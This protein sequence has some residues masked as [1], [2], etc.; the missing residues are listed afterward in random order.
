MRFRKVSDGTDR[1]GL[2]GKLLSAIPPARKVLELGRVM[3]GLTRRYKLR[4]ASA[5]WHRADIGATPPDEDG[6][7]LDRIQTVNCDTPDLDGFDDDYDCIVIGDA[8]SQV[9]NPQRL[10]T[11]L[12]RITTKDARLIC[13]VANATHVSVLEQMLL[14]E[15]SSPGDGGTDHGR[16]W[17]FSQSSVF[18]L[19]LDSGWLPQLKDSNRAN[20]PNRALAASVTAGSREL[21]VSQEAAERILNTHRMIVVCTKGEEAPAVAAVPISVIVPVNNEVQFD[22]NVA[23]SPG[24]HEIGAQ[25]VPCRGA[26]SA[27]DALKQG[28]ARATGEWLV[29]CHQDVYFPAGSGACLSALL[30]QVPPEQAPGTILGFSGIGSSLP[31]DPYAHTFHSGLVIDRVDCYDLPA[32]EHAVSVDELAI[33]LHRDTRAVIDPALGWHLWATDLCLAALRHGPGMQARIVR[34]PLFHN[35]MTGHAFIPAFH[36]SGRKLAAKYPEIRGIRTLCGTI[37]ATS[38]GR[39]LQGSRAWHGAKSVIRRARARLRISFAAD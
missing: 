29:F 34:V 33:V 16:R 35:S 25:I 20:H 10:V 6:A 32:S 27:A 14:G 2:D 4:H 1:T 17:R 3:P 30:A 13:C 11:E 21:G 24:L 19:L 28:R 37:A 31:S 9:V 26:R 22:L 39:M 18:K 36:A 7:H 5:K 15:L 23:A 12:R 38:A 8:L